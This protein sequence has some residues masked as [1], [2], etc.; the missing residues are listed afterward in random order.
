MIWLWAVRP[1]TL[2]L[3]AS[4]IVLGY[5]LAL[6]RGPASALVFI[7]AL[8]MAVL[9]QALSNLANDY[10]DAVAGT[11]TKERLGPTRM[12]GSGLTTPQKMFQ[13]IV[14]LAL[15]AASSGS[16]LVLTAAWG[17]WPLLFFFA[18]LGALSVAAA[19]LYTVGKRP[20]GYCGLGDF[21]AGFFFGPVPVWGTAVLCGAGAE[22][23]LFLPGMAAGFCSTMVLNVN[24]MRDIETDKKAG[25]K[26]VAVRLGLARAQ[27][28]HITLC[29]LTFLCWAVFWGTR[30]ATYLPALILCLPLATSV[31]RAVTRTKDPAN[32]NRQLKNTVLSSALLSGGMGVLCAFARY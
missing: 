20:Y 15:L 3:A 28:Y 12:V 26:T 27:K 19:I 14:F 32:M 21:M 30:N 1:R 9:L 25:K 8:A 18:L 2:P 17:N 22:A 7:F 29:A 31:C 5:G 4:A 24:N 16:A 23:Y 11:D 10:G 6:M 13:G